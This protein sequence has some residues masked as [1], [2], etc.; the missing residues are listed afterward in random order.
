M[1]DLRIRQPRAFT[2]VELLV[3]IAIIGILVALLLPAVQS[4]REA[5]RRMQ[6]KNQIKQ[7]GLGCLLHLDTHGFLPSGGWD[8]DWS[9]DPD[10]GYGESQPGGWPY[11][12][13]T[14]IEQQQLR[15][16]GEGTTGNRRDWERASTQLH[17][18]PVTAFICPSRR[19]ASVYKGAWISVNEQPWLASLS[20]TSGVAKSDYAA[21]SGTSRYF[22]GEQYGNPTSYQQAD[23][24]PRWKSSDDCNDP[25]DVRGFRRCQSGVIHHR[26]EIKIS[27]ITD[28]TTHTYLLGEKFMET[29]NY[30][31]SLDGAKRDYGDNQSIFVGF[32]WDNHR[33]AF[34][35]ISAEDDPDF[36]QPIQD[37]PGVDVFPNYR[38][39]SAHASG[40]NAV[41]CDGSVQLIAYDIDFQVHADLANRMDGNVVTLD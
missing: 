40:Y 31:G 37:T 8:Y 33:V 12:I 23:T 25:R 18:T 20:Q 29:D 4:A 16:L 11:S 5:A 6:C 19:S 24:N 2:L 30:D 41:M 10:R 7:L 38:F 17:Q 34:G 13:L 15:D 27:R 14:Y 35:P 1:L 9:A 21:N 36:Y 28:G 39:G 22:D 3:V 32:D 26:S